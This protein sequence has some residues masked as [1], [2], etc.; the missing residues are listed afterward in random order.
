M[1]IENQVDGDIKSTWSLGAFGNGDESPTLNGY[2]MGK[3]NDM[4]II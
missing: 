2:F 1:N 3:K 4:V